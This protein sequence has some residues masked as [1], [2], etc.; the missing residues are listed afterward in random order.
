V[1]SGRLA[2][3]AAGRLGRRP[4]LATTLLRLPRAL[5]SGPRSSL[6]RSFSWQ[7]AKRVRLETTVSVAG[8]SMME[9]STADQVGRVLAISGVWEPNATAVFRSLLRPGDVCLDIGAHIGYFT[10]LAS[11]LVG[12][13]GHVYAFEPSPATYEALLANLRRNDAANVTAF[14][15]A[16]GDAPGQALLHEGPGTNTGRST[17]RD[18]QPNAA[19]FTTPGVTVDV[20]TPVSCVP[21]DDLRRIRVVKID[22]EGYEVEVLSGLVPIFELGEPLAVLVEFNPLWSAHERAVEDVTGLCR[23]HGFAL[24]RVSAGYSL[25]TLFP[26]RVAA[27]VPIDAVPPHECDLLLTR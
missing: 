8:G 19:P 11:R 9:V 2:A 13:G 6:Y 24:Q 5:P 20:R 16:A 17:L 15:F 4:R 21:E 14:P 25:E 12:P 23:E 7:L 3:A 26:A 1:S 22:V 10:L 18:T 27:P